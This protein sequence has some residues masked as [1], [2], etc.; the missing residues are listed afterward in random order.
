M[1]KYLIRKI[2]GTENERYL[3]SI[4]PLVTRIN[5]LE[6]SIQPLSDDALVAKTAE[7]KQR[8]ANG[9]SLDSLLPE[10]F[11][12]VREA[13]KRALGMRHYDVQLIGGIVLHQGKIAEMKT[14]EGKTLVATLP[15]YLNA[16]EGR[17]AHLVTVNDYLA[18]RDAEWMGRIYRFLGLS[19]G[20]ILNGMGTKDKR[21]AY[22][23]DITYG[24]NSEF[25][26]DYLRDNMKFDIGNYVQRDLRYAIVDEVDSILIDEARTPLIISGPSDESTD[27]YVK[28]DAVVKRLREEEDFTKDEKAKNA[29]LTQEGIYKVERM[30]GVQN[31]Y[32]P[33]N[34]EL[35]HHVQQALK[36]VFMFH[37]DVDYVIK[38]VDGVDKVMI[39][40]EFTGRI[41]DGRRYSDGL[42][43][44]LEAK[45]GVKVERENQTLATITYQ[46][47]FRM[48]DKLAGMTGT[49]DTEAREFA[50]IYNLAVRVIPTNKPV[51]RNDMPDQI[52]K[53][54]EAKER[55]VI[56]EILE[57]NAK[58]QPVL[59]GTVSVEKSER[60]S[61]LLTEQG[62]KHNV[63]NAKF[64]MKEADVVAQAG[65]KGT[66]T[67]ATNMAGRG[68]DIVLGGNPEKLALAEAE[69]VMEELDTESQEYKDILEKYEKICAEEKKEVLAAGGLHIVG[70]ERHESRRIDNQLR[71]RSGRQGDPGSSRFFLSLDD[72]L[73]RIFGGE[74]LVKAMERLGLEEDQP[75]EHKMI[76]K[77]IENAQKK[78]EG[79]NFGIR[80]N[81]L[82]YDDV[83]NQQRKTIYAL[84]R[85]ILT[86]GEKNKQ[87][88][89][90]MIESIINTGLTSIIP[91]RT[92]PDTWNYGQVKELL[93][94]VMTYNEEARAMLD[95]SIFE[96]ILNSSDYTSLKPEPALQLLAQRCYDFLLEQ[97][98]KKISQFDAA[99]SQEIERHI[100]LEVLDIFWRRHLLNM[101]HLR[102]G[103]GLR[104]YGQ[105]NPKL[106]YKREGFAMFNDMM[107]SIYTESIK[108]LFSVQVVTEEAVEKF[109]K[110][111]QKKEA[112][113]QK[114]TTAPVE[115]EPT[116]RT[117]PK[118]GRNDDCPCGSGKKFKRCCMGK[119]IYD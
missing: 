25:G 21:R 118:I 38:N 117:T 15:M 74:R 109:E 37:L 49:A 103:I 87:V 84:R 10:A 61:K 55:A 77:S 44:A 9:E 88:I 54:Q 30:L 40:D 105:K 31:L 48:Y 23:S 112:E 62:I 91:E 42:H 90:S 94:G 17:G 35:V 102:E 83:M 78:V 82:E 73:M 104:G 32:A 97:Y 65:R 63:L 41:M 5:E 18:S 115:K 26:F 34:L 92:L 57:K 39:V 64:H 114:N 71:G 13:G 106:E 53:T 6:S 100:V 59:V 47:F 28:V 29:I 46:N 50:E 113:V 58:G 45:E 99:L 95:D 33:E 93:A 16:L 4:R 85:N 56:K 69:S 8:V 107:D 12:V 36:A 111:E 76:S 22:N 108:R 19:V 43:Q 110:K 27:L 86:G 66:I 3:K 89:Y 116:K 72:D 11:A 70:T 98:D 96:P 119:G 60:L 81:V 1:F 51:I 24:T 75:I 14:G 52:Y 7:F 20:T 68:T 80:K 67:I 79:H 101:D 2:F